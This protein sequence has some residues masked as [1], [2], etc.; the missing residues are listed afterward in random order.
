MRLRTP[1]KVGGHLR[2]P[3]VGVDPG[4][5]AGQAGIAAALG[6]LIAPLA[7]VVAFV[8]PGLAED[9]DCSALFAEA[10]AQGASVETAQI[11]S[12]R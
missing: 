4:K 5:T 2:K 8:D 7:A 1:I 11:S 6:A 12:E 9:A 10:K 3:S